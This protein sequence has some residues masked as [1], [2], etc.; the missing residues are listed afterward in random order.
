MNT[1]QINE[2]KKAAIG[3]L[4]NYLGQYNN[5]PTVGALDPDKVLSL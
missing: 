4:E 1:P 3:L 2:V 5:I